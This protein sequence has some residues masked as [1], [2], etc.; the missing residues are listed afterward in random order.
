MIGFLSFGIFKSKDKV[1]YQW[2]FLFF[3]IYL[4]FMIYVFSDEE[5]FKYGNSLV[6]LF[7]GGMF[8]VSHFLIIGLLNIYKLMGKK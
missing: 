8:V 5:N 4:S 1:F 3:G 7:Y 6:I 2:N